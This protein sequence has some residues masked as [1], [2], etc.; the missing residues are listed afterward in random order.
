MKE[1]VRKLNKIAEKNDFPE[2]LRFIYESDGTVDIIKFGQYELYSSEYDILPITNIQ[3][4]LIL[5]EDILFS[6][7]KRQYNIMKTEIQNLKIK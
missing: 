3:D 4:E 5:D 6:F 2:N 7:V 1:T